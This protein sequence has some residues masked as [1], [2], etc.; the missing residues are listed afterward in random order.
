[1]DGFVVRSFSLCRVSLFNGSL[2]ELPRKH[3][4]HIPTAVNEEPLLVVVLVET[5]VS[6]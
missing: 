1:M 5:L 6:N 2:L 3:F 4:Y